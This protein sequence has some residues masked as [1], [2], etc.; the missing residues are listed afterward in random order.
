MYPEPA[1]HRPAWGLGGKTD[2]RR[3]LSAWPPPSLSRCCHSCRCLSDIETQ[4][5]RAAAV[6]RSIFKEE[7]DHHSS[8][9][10]QREPEPRMFNHALA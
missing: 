4:A 7:R 8:E 9:R 6:T 2:A 3:H 5:I 10:G 1:E